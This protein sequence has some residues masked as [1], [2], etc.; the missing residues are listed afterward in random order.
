MEKKYLCFLLGVISVTAKAAVPTAE[1]LKGYYS[2]GQVCVCIQFAEPVCNDIVWCGTYNG[3]S[4]NL[5]SLSRFQP[6]NNFEGWYVVAFYDNNNPVNGKPV[7]LKDDG[8]FEWKYQTGDVT[9]WTIHSGTATP[10]VGSW[11]GESEL[12]SIGNAT[13]VIATSSGWKNEVSCIK[14]AKPEPSKTLPV[15]YINTKNGDPITSKDTYLKAYYYLDNMGLEGYTSIASKEKPD[16]MQIKGRGN[17]TWSGFDKKPYRLKLNNKQALMGLEKSK[18][19]TLLAH[20]DDQFG[21]LKNTVGF[22]MS[23]QMDLKWTPKQAALEVVLNGDYI[24]LYMLTEQIRVDKKRVNI[25]EQ[26]DEETDPEKI[27][28]GWLVEIDNYDEEGNITFTEPANKWHGEQKVM[29]TP[30]TPEVLSTQQYTYLQDQMTGINN[31]LYYGSE[32]TLADIM[33]MDEAAKYYLVCELMSDCES[34]HGSCYLHKDVNDNVNVNQKWFFGPVW[35]FGNSFKDRNRFIYDQPE[36]S[37][38]W[39]GQLAGKDVFNQSRNRLWKHWKY[40]DYEQIEA[41]VDSFTTLIKDAAKNDAARWPQYNHAD[42]TSQKDTFLDMYNRHVNWLTNQWGEGE[43]DKPTEL[44]MQNAQCTMHNG[45]V[46]IDGQLYILRN[47][48][49]YTIL[50]RR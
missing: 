8:S 1:D 39:I 36:F 6:V 10:T 12:K 45:K 32:S 14:P 20:A 16:T 47:G 25:V 23:E 26:A 37:Q 21:W 27:T 22:Y 13:P 4:T 2:S 28:G 35:D 18:H 44:E 40:Y 50:G 31:T 43:G 48:E 24:G 30:N 49:K 9:T 33:D 5:S 46:L 42:V 38:I 3:W 11:S 19:W 29:I 34:Y 15:L 7:Q 41:M 17:W